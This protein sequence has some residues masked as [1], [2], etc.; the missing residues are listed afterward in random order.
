M[1]SVRL[2]G[3]FEFELNGACF[4]VKGEFEFD[5]E[6]LAAKLLAAGALDTPQSAW[7]N[8]DSA[9]RYLDVSPQRLR[10]LQARRE[11][12]YYQEAPGCRVLFRRTELDQWMSQHHQPERRAP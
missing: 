3:K 9:A 1:R 6:K 10:K 2:P 12:P 5:E 4:V 7:M 8:V 11:V